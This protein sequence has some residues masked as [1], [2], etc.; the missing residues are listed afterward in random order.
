MATTTSQWHDIH[1]YDGQAA[2]F[3]VRVV[4]SQWEPP[5]PS[6]AATVEDVKRA[7]ADPDVAKSAAIAGLGAA[8]ARGADHFA[9]EDI[10]D[11]LN[12]GVSVQDSL[13]VAW[14]LAREA[15]EED[16]V[17]LGLVD[18]VVTNG[19]CPSGRSIRM[20][21]VV[22]ALAPSVLHVEAHHPTGG[23]QEEL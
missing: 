16:L 5:L 11:P 8:V 10:T 2:P 14:A 6:I 23:G 20:L 9:A 12:F 21:Q 18:M 19:F 3:A 13:R 4:K 15:K 22:G 1:A 17:F 7:F